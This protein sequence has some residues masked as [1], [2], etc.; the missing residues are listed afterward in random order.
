MLSISVWRLCFFQM[1]PSACHDVPHVFFWGIDSARTCSW[2]KQCCLIMNLERWHFFAGCFILMTSMVWYHFSYSKKTLFSIPGFKFFVSIY[3][4]IYIYWY[5][6][7]QQFPGLCWVLG[8]IHIINQER[9]E[10]W[11]RCRRRCA[12]NDRRY[13]RRWRPDAVMAMWCLQSRSIWCSLQSHF[14][15][16]LIADDDR[17]FLGLET[18]QV[19][20][21]AA[22]AEAA[23]PSLTWLAVS[24]FCALGWS[25]NGW[26][27]WD[28]GISNCH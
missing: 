12:S 4:I 23:E 19:L 5:S 27:L 22:M 21:I 26:Y 24:P 14:I 13:R 10:L 17:P 3:I 28:L 7:I 18:V 11:P 25:N 6:F 1:N 20:A 2:W 9:L 16:R 15:A 8:P